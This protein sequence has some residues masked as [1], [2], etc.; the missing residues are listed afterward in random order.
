MVIFSCYK[1]QRLQ[2]SKANYSFTITISKHFPIYF[3]HFCSTTF[4]YTSRVDWGQPMYHCLPPLPP[5]PTNHE[6]IVAK[7]LWNLK[8][9]GITFWIRPHLC[10]AGRID[11][12]KNVEKAKNSLDSRLI[13]LESSPGKICLKVEPHKIE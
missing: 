13:L 3:L 7:I 8:H 12:R 11:A 4:E 1:W 6:E 9:F 2:T 5:T 10:I